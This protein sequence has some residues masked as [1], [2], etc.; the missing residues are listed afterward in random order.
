MISM[1]GYIDSVLLKDIIERHK[2]SNI[3]DRKIFDREVKGLVSAMDELA[4]S[5]GTIKNRKKITAQS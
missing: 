1:E 3:S 4:V 5:S 2:L